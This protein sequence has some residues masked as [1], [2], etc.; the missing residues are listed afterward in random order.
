M[1]SGKNLWRAA[2][3]C[4]YSLLQLADGGFL[5]AGN[6]ESYGNGNPD[7]Y[8]LRTDAAG[9]QIWQKT[10]GGSGSDYGWFLLEAPDAGYAIAGEKESPG[11]K[12]PI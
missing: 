10:Y 1:C 7:V 5:I 8:L 3:D 4:G 12:G 6:A 2:S 9:E 11:S